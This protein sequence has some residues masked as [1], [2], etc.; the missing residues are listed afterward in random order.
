MERIY[1][2]EKIEKA[3][4]RLPTLGKEL[5]LGMIVVFICYGATLFK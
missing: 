5:T 1:V 4:E 3:W 2:M